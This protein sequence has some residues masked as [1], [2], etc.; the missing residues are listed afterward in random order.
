MLCEPTYLV[1]SSKLA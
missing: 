1:V